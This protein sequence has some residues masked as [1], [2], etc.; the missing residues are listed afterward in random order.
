M[1]CHIHC[2]IISG[3]K[4]RSLKQYGVGWP[5]Q[6][7]ENTIEVLVVADG[8][9]ILHHD[10]DVKQ[11]ILHLMNVVDTIFRDRSLGNHVKVEVVKVMAVDGG[12]FGY[13]RHMTRVSAA[14]MLSSFCKWQKLL[15]Q[16]DHSGPL[17]YDVALL[18]TRYK[19]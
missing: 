16:Y 15:N 3:R 4:K 1:L 9:M 19:P 12:S 8:S 13:M 10:D 11:Y 2:D 18:I 5:P 6:S 14:E 7:Y 17:L